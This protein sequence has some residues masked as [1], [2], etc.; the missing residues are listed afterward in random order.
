MIVPLRFLTKK[1]QEE[2]RK[3]LNELGFE[4]LVDK[5]NTKGWSRES[6]IMLAK[7]MLQ[8]STVKEKEK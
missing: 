4:G 6:A 3:R 1:E 7:A 8:D 5:M 2:L